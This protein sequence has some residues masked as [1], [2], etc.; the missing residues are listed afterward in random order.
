MPSPKEKR[1]I[2]SNSEAETIKVG[3]DLAQSMKSGDLIILSGPLGSGK[4]CLIR[5]LAIGLGVAPD[6]INSPSFT[7]VNEYY[8][9][10]MPLFHLDL[11]RIKDDSELCQIGWDDY[12]LR[13]GAVVVEWGEK[14][15]RYIPKRRAE[16]IISIVSEISREILMEFFE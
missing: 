16:I 15:R 6:E 7:I 10:R 9:G 13:D 1:R 3:Y 8:G 11:Y 5:G 12:L 4:T 2:V 14:A